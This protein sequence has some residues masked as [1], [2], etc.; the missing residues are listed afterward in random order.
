MVGEDQI[1]SMKEGLPYAIGNWSNLSRTLTLFAGSMF[2][3]F[4]SFVGVY[5]FILSRPNLEIELKDE[6]G[7]VLS[8]QANNKVGQFLLPA[9]AG[10]T[11][12]GFTIKP[13][14]SVEVQAYGKVHLGFHR[15]VDAAKE[16]FV[17][18]FPWIGPKGSEFIAETEA[19]RTRQQ[20]L[21]DP[22]ANIGMLLG[23][24]AYDKEPTKSN[25]QPDKIVSI[26]DK[27]TIKNTHQEEQMLFFVVNDMYL[28]NDAKEA[29]IGNAEGNLDKYQKNWNE[30][31][32]KKYWELWFDDNIGQYLIN[33]KYIN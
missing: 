17:P 26:G 22:T 20:L 29:Y 15:L 7:I 23:Y 19:D 6:G 16:D 24:L 28:N 13:E 10:W 27:Q 3:L 32:D 9:S 33:I 25:P 21:V 4:L 2:I 18:I 5:S 14:E 30:I 1:E 8:N 12:S 11:N 31:K